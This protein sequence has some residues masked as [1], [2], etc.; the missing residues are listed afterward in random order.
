MAERWTTIDERNEWLRARA[1][2]PELDDEERVKRADRAMLDVRDRSP[3][4]DVV[5][6]DSILKFV[7]EVR[8]A[9]EGM[10]KEIVETDQAVASAKS[11]VEDVVRGMEAHGE[12]LRLAQAATQEAANMARACM[13]RE[14]AN[15]K[16]IERFRLTVGTLHAVNIRV[17]GEE[18]FAKIHEEVAGSG[19]AERFQ[20]ALADAAKSDG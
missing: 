7:A 17:I 8:A 1:E 12:S 14:A 16:T 6:Q 19:E 2:R 4:I 18:A 5:T 10:R 11:D 13:E 15:L 3:A 20:K 9:I